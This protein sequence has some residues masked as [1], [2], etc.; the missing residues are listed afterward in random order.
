MPVY[1]CVRVRDKLDP[2]H[3]MPGRFMPHPAH[4]AHLEHA[5]GEAVNLDHVATPVKAWAAVLPAWMMFALLDACA[6]IAVTSGLDPYLVS[7]VRFA[8]HTIVILVLL[9]VW[10]HPRDFLPNRWGVQALRGATLAL[11]TFTNFQALQTLPLATTMAIYLAIPMVVTALSGPMLGEWAGW[12]RWLA[13]LLGFAGVMIVVRPGT[14]SF[15]WAMLWS[16]ASLMC[17][18][19][20]FVMTRAMAGTE[21]DESMILIAGA[22][23]ALLLLLPAT[24]TATMPQGWHVWLALA[25]TGVLGSVGHLFIIRASRLAPAPAIAPAVFTQILWSVLFGW[26]FFAHLPD[27]WTLVGIGVIALSGAYIFRRERQLLRRA[28]AATPG[29][30][31]RMDQ[32]VSHDRR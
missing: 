13:V 24:A 6:K 16:L 22:L 20:Y 29:M 9:R 23:P 11:G 27:G 21:R 31:S 19:L 3:R 28:D 25:A 26:L 30:V 8:G 18:S 10:A 4:A 1:R 17:A 2:S 15:Q 5:R 7:F 14:E 32:T 12:R